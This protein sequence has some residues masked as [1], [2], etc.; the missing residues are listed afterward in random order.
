MPVTFEQFDDTIL[1]VTISE[2][3][4]VE[5]VNKAFTDTVFPFCNALAPQKAQII[6]DITTLQWDR[7]ELVEYLSTTRENNEQGDVP[8]NMQQHLI[9]KSEWGES[10]RSWLNINYN[11]QIHL[12]PDLKS[13]LKYIRFHIKSD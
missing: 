6:Y 10:L 11:R 3:S 8:T 5:D 2:K 4:L 12:F 13:V 7:N 9:G 1:L